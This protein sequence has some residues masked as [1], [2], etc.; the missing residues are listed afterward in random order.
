MVEITA[1]ERNIEKR[2]ERNEDSLRDL[3]DNIKH[4]HLHYRGLRRR[5]KGPEK[6]F[7]EMVAENF[8]NV[9]NGEGSGTPLQYSCLENPKDGG[10]WLAAVYGVA[11]SRTRL[12]RLSSNLGKE[13]VNQVLEVQSPRQDKLRKNT[14]RHILIKLTKIKDKNKVSKATREKQQ[15]TYKGTPIRLSADFSTETLKARKE[16]HDIFK[17][18][19]GKILPPRILYSERLL[20]RL[21]REI[22]SFPDK[23]KLKRIWYQQSSCTTNAKGTTLGRKCKRRKKPAKNERKTIRKMVIGSYISI[24][25]LNVNGLS[26][27]TGRHRLD[28]L[29]G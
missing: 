22:K 10:A 21:D 7:E 28:W 1:T 29:G 27:S 2:M 3:W 24:I 19:N 23:Q 13:I 18:M 17:V 20:F 5:E 9:G 14:L 11:Q 25:T 16:W 6:I 4:K 15:I 12:K 8:P 26:A